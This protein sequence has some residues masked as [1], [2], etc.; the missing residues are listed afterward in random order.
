MTYR[1]REPFRTQRSEFAGDPDG[2]LRKEVTRNA[3]PPALGDSVSIKSSALRCYAR[4][5][6]PDQSSGRSEEVMSVFYKA[7]GYGKTAWPKPFT[8]PQSRKSPFIAIN[9]A[10][11]ATY[12]DRTGSH[13]KG[14]YRC[15]RKEG[16]FD[17]MARARSI[18]MKSRNGYNLQAQAFCVLERKFRRGGR[19]ER[20]N[21]QGARDSLVESRPDARERAG[22]FAWT[23][24]IALP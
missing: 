14:A 13:E 2:N 15:M 8:T 22:I 3:R 7:S 6:A 12:R 16:C 20:W 11:P 23:C 10:M 19:S 1:Q 17:T 18:G 24:L 21:R 9:C 5:F 4:L